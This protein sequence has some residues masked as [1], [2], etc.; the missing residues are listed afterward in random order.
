MQ[1]L[2]GT[3]VDKDS[4]LERLLSGSGGTLALAFVCNKVKPVL[5]GGMRPPICMRDVMYVHFRAFSAP[6]P[7]IAAGGGHP[8]PCISFAVPAVPLPH[9]PPH[10]FC[11]HTGGRAAPSG[12]AN[13]AAKGID[14]RS[15]P[16]RGNLLL[17]PRG[18][19]PCANLLVRQWH[20]EDPHRKGR[21]RPLTSSTTRIFCAPLRNSGC[22]LCGRCQSTLLNHHSGWSFRNFSIRSNSFA[23]F[24]SR[25]WVAG[26]IAD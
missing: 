23:W 19:N 12:D 25:P 9:S 16:H 21:Q 6:C 10:H 20:A 22:P 2:E 17:K 15:L 1:G 11:P 8:T 4:W 3:E 13:K 24:A 5:F 18:N 26:R 7:L 14:I